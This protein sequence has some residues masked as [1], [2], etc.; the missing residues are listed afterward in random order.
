MIRLIILVVLALAAIGVALLLQRRRPDPPSA[1]SYRA[2]VQLDRNDFDRPDVPHLLV[3]FASITCNTCPEV[4]A[5]VE[6]FTADD[7]VVQRVDVEGGGDLHRRY[8]IDGVPTTVV[9]DAQGVV[10]ATFFGPVLDEDLYEAVD[11]LRN[12]SSGGFG[13]P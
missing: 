12:R 2:P 11:Q 13:E 10:T 5:Q 9:A 3:V 6:P 8:R 1:P 4:W 7:L